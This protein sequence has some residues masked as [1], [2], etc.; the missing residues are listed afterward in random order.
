MRA[1]A[2]LDALLLSAD[3][4]ACSAIEYEAVP[5]KVTRKLD[6]RKR[7]NTPR[8]T[9]QWVW[10]CWRLATSLL[11]LNIKSFGLNGKNVGL[12]KKHPG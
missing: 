6:L 2:D 12:P 7:C 11:R 10:A 4:S 1:P 8:M 5:D 3:I 9:S